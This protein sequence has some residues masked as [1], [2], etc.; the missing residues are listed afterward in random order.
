MSMFKDIPVEVGVIFEG[1]RVRRPDMYLELGGP[2]IDAKFEL[3]KARK[4]DE[5]KDGKI[6][7]IGPDIKDMKEGSSNHFGLYIEVARG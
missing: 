4:L 7:I 2:K 5:I 3:V 6:S 1:E